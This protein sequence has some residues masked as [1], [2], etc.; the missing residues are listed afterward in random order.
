MP[1]NLK[2]SIALL[3][4]TPRTLNTLLRDLPE[5]WTHRNE[6]PNTWSPFEVAGHLIHAEHTDWIRRAKRI[7]ES[8]E[9]IAFEPFARGGHAQEIQ[10]KSLSQRLDEFSR[11]RAH[12]LADLRALR[13]RPEDLDR[14]GLHP[15]LGPVTLGPLL[16]TWVAHDLTHLH[17]ISRTLAHQYRAAVGP[18]SIYLGVLQCSAH[19]AAA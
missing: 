14:R 15:S 18:W 4:R 6:G 17:Q 9:A 19:S 8:G 12:S 2:D 11:V 1:H 13:L 10:G 3:E 7:V 16:A 5:S